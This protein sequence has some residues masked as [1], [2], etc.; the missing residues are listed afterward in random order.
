MKKNSV[1]RKVWAFVMS[2]IMMCGTLC[3]LPVENNSFILDVGAVK[4]T[5]GTTGNCSW[6]LNNDILTISGNGSMEDYQWKCRPWGNQIKEIIIDNGVTHIGNY[7]FWGCCYV[8]EVS[9]STTVSSIGDYAFGGVQSDIS[10][11]A[12]VR[13]IGKHSFN[14]NEK[15]K[16]LILKDGLLYIGEEAFQLCKNIERVY[17][18]GSVNK[19]D[20]YAFELCTKLSE[21][22]LK[23]GIKEIGCSVFR[24]CVAE[25][26]IVPNSIEFIDRQA[27][28]ECPN[29]KSVTLSSRMKTISYW[30]FDSCPQLSEVIIPNSINTIE[31]G[32]FRNCSKLTSIMI[33]ENVTKI[34]SSAFSGC[35]NLTIYGIKNSYAEIYANENNIP[36]VS[37]NGYT[38]ISTISADEIVLGGTATV[39]AKAVLGDGDYTYAVLYRKKTDTKWTVK[40]NYSTNDTITIK[41]AKATDYDVCVKV[42]DSTGKIVKKFFEV[43]V[44]DKLKNTSTISATTI[45]KGDTVTLNGSATGGMG[46]YTYAVLYKKKAETKWTT[47]QG[48]KDNSEILVRP[49]TNTDYDICIKVKDNDGTIAK[50]YFTVTVTK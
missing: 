42:K 35:D 47:R 21:L 38:N 27:F 20:N 46:D 2:A 34:N 17:I 37:V 30:L 32:A 3:Y 49:Y 23:N 26:I 10:I 13:K 7:A 44:N 18:P 8:H 28:A 16:N 29:L 25:K 41:P 9:I 50:K 12:T 39:N 45:K 1:L 14:S 22:E 48:Y 24:Y 11:P 15:I 4:A 6:W 19:I 36:F 40:Q 31:E 5:Y 33:P 43:K